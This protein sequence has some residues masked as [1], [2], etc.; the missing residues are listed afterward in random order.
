MAYGTSAIAKG[1]RNGRAMLGHLP[2]RTDGAPTATGMM[3]SAKEW[4]RAARRL[5]GAVA[6]ALLVL[7]S[8]RA[9]AQT[10][11]ALAAADRL[12]AVQK[13]G[14]L[15]KDTA[16]GVAER[17]P[18]ATDAQKQAFIK[19]MTDPDFLARYQAQ[20]RIAFSKHL[21]V[22]EMDALSDFYSK[23]IAISAMKKMG[24][25]SAELMTFIQSEIP[26]MVARI[27]KTP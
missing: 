5:I 24:A 3:D 19:E 6:L 9:I 27:M 25:T 13:P 26:A 21:T 22:E 15:M 14:E 4:T 1:G 8:G 10:P 20:M 7:A 16:I 17:L 12:I 23:P 2:P 18:G 11:Q